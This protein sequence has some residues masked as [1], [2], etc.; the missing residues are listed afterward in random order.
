MICL[1][2]ETDMFRL[3]GV[4]SSYKIGFFYASRRFH[5]AILT[6]FTSLW[7]Q[8]PFVYISRETSFIGPLPNSH[9]KLQHPLIPQNAKGRRFEPGLGQC[10]FEDFCCMLTYVQFFKENYDDVLPQHF[11][12]LIN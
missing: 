4:P 6:L 9:F 8:T 11:R 12:K 10:V 3:A 5:T 2:S 7:L 1:T